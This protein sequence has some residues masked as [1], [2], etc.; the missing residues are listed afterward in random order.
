MPLT[1]K[2][3]GSAVDFK[4]VPAGTHIAVCDQVVYLGIQPGSGMYPKSKPQ[5]W[6]RFQLPS[7]QIEFE[8][9]GKK[10]TGPRVI[11]KTY[12]ASMNEKA[13]L[14]HDLESW[15]GKGFTDEEAEKL[16]VAGLLS[17]VCMLSV[18]HITKGD[19]IYANITSLGKLMKGIDPKTILIDPKTPAIYYGPDATDTYAKLPK[20]LCEK[21]DGQILEKPAAQSN[22]DSDDGSDFQASYD[23]LPPE[24]GDDPE[25][26]PF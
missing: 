21:I 26:C 8:R 16:D 7:E 20:W 23:D 1:F 14:R 3:G 5:V 10:L 11:G 24:M 25:S 6:I 17:K 4:P 19:K 12:T 22:P 2:T 13:N 15:R 18:T 9:D